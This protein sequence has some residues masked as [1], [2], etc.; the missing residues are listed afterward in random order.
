MDFLNSLLENAQVPFLSAFILGL[1]TAISPC[2]MA[3]NITAIGFISKDIENRKK[4]FI[5]GIVYTLGRSISYSILGVLFYVGISQFAFESALQLWGERL[6]GPL[7]IVIGVFMLGIINI[8]FPALSKLTNKLEESS[9][10]SF[11]GVLLLGIVF[12]LAFCPYSGV[13]YFGMLIPMALSSVSGLYLPFVFALA[14]GIPVII[15]A[16]ILAFSINAVGGIY[17][18]MKSFEYWFRRVVAV[19]FLI[20]GLYYSITILLGIQL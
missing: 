10:N 8:N 16:W 13:L 2:P 18:K 19:V 15:F 20:V 7:L 12:A 1:M 9:K 3:T 6:L 17:N 4:V 11:W 5:N 14:T